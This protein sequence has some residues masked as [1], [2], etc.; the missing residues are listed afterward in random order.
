MLVLRVLRNDSLHGYAIAQ[1][2]RELSNS[3][4]EAE[5]GSL[6]PALQ[7]MLL[8]GWV[9]AEWQQSE[10]NRRAR[11][12]KLTPAGRKQMAREAKRRRFAEALAQAFL[13]DGLPWNWS[14]WKLHFP[15]FTPILDFI[16]VLS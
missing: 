10:N 8:K 7:R 12:Y 13:G 9:V 3:V 6:Y 2:I 5:E 1:R 4:L 15:D 16:H 11:Y 14:I